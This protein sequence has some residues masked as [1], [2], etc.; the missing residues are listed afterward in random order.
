MEMKDGQ[1]VQIAHLVRD[2][3]KTLERYWNDFK[4][5][6][7]DLHTYGPHNV[8]NSMYRGK[9]SDHTYRIAVVWTGP[10]QIEVMQPLTGRSIYDEFLETKGEGIHHYK[11]YYRD[12]RKAVK[13]F[14]SRGYAVIQSGN[15]GEDEFYY[16]ETEAKMGGAVIELGNAGSI[17]PATAFYPAEAFAS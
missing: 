5:G 16:L 12:C 14:E 8:Q 17:P 7:W 6:P 11:L 10:V 4:M 9:P 1:I 2:L 13:D 15:I 3:D